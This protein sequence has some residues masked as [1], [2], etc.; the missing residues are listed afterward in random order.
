MKR[1]RAIKE[2]I[3]ITDDDNV[4]REVGSQSSSSALS[5]IVAGHDVQPLVR[6]NESR[7]RVRLRM[8]QLHTCLGAVLLLGAVIVAGSGSLPAVNLSVDSVR[9]AADQEAVVSIRVM[10]PNGIAAASLTLAFDTDALELVGWETLL[11]PSFVEQFAEIDDEPFFGET[12]EYQGELYERPVAL[13]IVD[14]VGLRMAGVRLVPAGP[15]ESRLLDLRFRL[16]PGAEPGFYPLDIEPT[17]LRSID[18]GYP[19]DGISIDPLL[20]WITPTPDTPESDYPSILTADGL[21]DAAPRG[22]LTFTFLFS[23]ESRNQLDDGWEI[24]Y[25]GATGLTG[26]LDDWDQDG[27]IN[28]LEY[29]HG[30]NPTV[31]SSIPQMHPVKTA[32]D[33][34]LIRF[35]IAPTIMIFEVETSTDLIRWTSLPPDTVTMTLRPDLGHTDNWT[36][37]EIS[38]PIPENAVHGHF[39]L[40]IGYP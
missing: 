37:L 22:W 14:K 28:I 18:A 30:G 16:K 15:N 31:R 5:V 33:R 23:D 38:V 8:C 19:E 20:T 25:F 4:L 26:P 21:T 39:R 34:L 12:L 36:M 6:V 9:L 40:R 35:P 13:R 2:R 3:T 10:P 24:R 32:D 1:Y 27:L 29:F 17:V 7:G 11:F